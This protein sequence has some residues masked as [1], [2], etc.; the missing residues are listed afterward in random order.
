MKII[1]QAITAAVAFIL[2][3]SAL[4][5]QV[6]VVNPGGI[7]AI[8]AP[9]ILPP[10]A[11]APVIA[12]TTPGAV[13]PLYS[14]LASAQSIAPPN[15]L[16]GGDQLGLTAATA[17]NLSPRQRMFAT[18]LAQADLSQLSTE[19]LQGARL[20]IGRALSS[21]LLPKDLLTLL[22]AEQ[23]RLEAELAQR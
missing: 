10:S 14:P 20:L 5:G 22:G 18:A 23:G 2:P 8:L 6:T 17:A 15:V 3:H 13:T 1:R 19:D 11:P 16:P 7:G 12:P 4:G 9:I 21:S